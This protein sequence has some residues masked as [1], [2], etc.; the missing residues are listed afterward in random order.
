M[1]NAIPLVKLSRSRCAGP[2]FS[3]PLT[4]SG[5]YSP[6]ATLTVKLKGDYHSG[7]KT[8]SGCGAAVRGW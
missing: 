7:N 8:D 2:E 6:E 5:Y 4:H 1:Y 3:K